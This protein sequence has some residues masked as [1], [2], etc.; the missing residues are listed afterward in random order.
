MS[1]HSDTP[2]SDA[3]QRWKM[4]TIFAAVFAAVSAVVRYGVIPHL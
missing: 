1:I 4:I 3:K 2:Y